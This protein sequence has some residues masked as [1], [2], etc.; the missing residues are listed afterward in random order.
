[1]T[2]QSEHIKGRKYYGTPPKKHH[3]TNNRI[4]DDFSVCVPRPRPAC[5]QELHQI[6]V[7][8]QVQASVNTRVT[9]AVYIY[10]YLFRIYLFWPLR[11][12][13]NDHIIPDDFLIS[14]FPF[15][16][17]CKGAMNT[18]QQM[19]STHVIR[20]HQRTPKS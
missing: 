11:H 9:K 15:M 5:Q 18:G 7:Y 19:E 12:V 2:I 14:L 17:S 16:C 3:K 8:V 6:Q 20:K 1:M 4:L 13:E 10:I